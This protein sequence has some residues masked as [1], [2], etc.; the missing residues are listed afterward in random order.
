MAALIGV[1][2]LVGASRRADPCVTIAR[3]GL[4]VQGEVRICPGA[5]RVPDPTEQGVLIVTGSDTRIDLTGVT[6]ESGDSAP[7]RYV[8]IGVIS[9]GNDDVE[10]VGGSIRGYRFGIRIERGR[11][12]RISGSDLS[13]SR[14]QALR[15]TPVKYDE[16]DWLDIFDPDTFETY[17]GGLYLK[18]TDGATVTGVTA[19]GA[20]N[21]IGLFG[22]NDSYVAENDVTGNSGWGIHLWQSS[23]NVIV[24]NIARRNVRCESASYSRGCDS[25]ALLLR[26]RCDSNLVADNDL[27]GS[28]DGF[29]LSGQP[30][31]M[32]ASNGNF[33]ARNNASFSPHNAFESTFSDGN[34]FLENRAD[35]SDYG[36]WLGYST[37]T[38]VRGSTVIGSKSAGIAI[39][40][41][42]DNEVRSNLVLGGHIGIRLFAPGGGVASRGTIIADNT[43]GRNGRGVVLEA[44]VASVVR[45]NVFD[46][47]GTALVVDSLGW[48]TTVTGNV[49]LGARDAWIVAPDLAAGDNYWAAGNVA[50]TVARVRGRISVLPWHPASA[51]GY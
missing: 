43:I 19:R 17:G 44:T 33:V 27:Q 2:P 41:G 28:G 32:G 5:Y 22:A 12:H 18:W 1:L 34:T 45:G 16:A 38:L 49:F 47:T 7:S 26:N 4:R 8:G 36:Y 9:R 15:S 46:A 6:I 31:E 25:A 21:G 24:R 50:A 40:H 11:G 35:S 39:E 30:P 37:H 3:A 10:I 23:H 13:G 48:G 14:A 51:A 29:F 42:R 20:Q